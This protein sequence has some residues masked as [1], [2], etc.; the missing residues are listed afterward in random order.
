L[1]RRHTFYSFFLLYSPTS[2]V[3]FLSREIGLFV[4]QEFWPF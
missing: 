1:S 3:S 4:K 2:L